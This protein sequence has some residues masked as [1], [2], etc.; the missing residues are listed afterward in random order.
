MQLYFSDNTCIISIESWIKSPTDKF[1]LLYIDKIKQNLRD[2][3]I[4][5]WATVLHWMILSHTR[6]LKCEDYKHIL[7]IHI[8]ISKPILYTSSILHL[9]H[10]FLF[11]SHCGWVKVQQR[12]H[13][14]SN[15]YDW[16]ARSNVDICNPARNCSHDLGLDM[17]VKLLLFAY[18]FLA[19]MTV[20][21]LNIDKIFD[22]KTYIYSFT[23]IQCN[24]DHGMIYT[25]ICLFF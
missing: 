17:Q 22:L 25:N 4:Q 16:N 15:V 18:R 12:L 14:S 11:H 8:K 24:S 2:M 19:N 1:V 5:T 21:I 6:R 7:L 20:L 3:N 23:Q 13:K 10:D 9:N